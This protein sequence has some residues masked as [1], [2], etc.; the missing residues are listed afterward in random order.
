MTVVE[1]KTG[2]P[3]P[4]HQAQLETYLAALRAQYSDVPIRGEV[5]YSP[6]GD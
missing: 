2:A 4:E 6:R 3:R 5:V 1:I